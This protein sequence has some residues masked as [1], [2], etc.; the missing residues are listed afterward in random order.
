MNEIFSTC[1]AK[2]LLFCKKIKCSCYW[3]GFAI[4]KDRIWC[5]NTLENR[6]NK[7]KRET[8]KISYTLWHSI[9]REWNPLTIIF[10]SFEDVNTLNKCFPHR[11]NVV[12]IENLGLHRVKARIFIFKYFV[13]DLHIK[14]TQ[15]IPYKMYSDK[16]RNLLLIQDLE[17]SRA[18]LSC[19][20]DCIY[21][22]TTIQS[23]SEKSRWNMKNCL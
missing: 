19:H 15:R 8:Q 13:V 3:H 21:T 6:E 4:I 22:N 20:A 16:H 9:S 23:T 18:Y 2:R 7:R 5:E 11:T 14:N 1:F 10:V 17:P 12:W